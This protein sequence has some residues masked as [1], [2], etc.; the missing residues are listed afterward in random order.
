M[1]SSDS[2]FSIGSVSLMTNSNLKCMCKPLPDS[3]SSSLASSAAA[4]APAPVPAA[5]PA[6]VAAAAPPPEPTFSS[7]SL[8]SLPSS[9]WSFLSALLYPCPADFTGSIPLKTALSRSARRL[10]HRQ[11][12]SGSEVYRPKSMLV[13]DHRMLALVGGLAVISTPSSARM[14]AA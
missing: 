4:S 12:L 5:P 10:P 9:A 1:S 11:P 2:S 13:S 14:R 7:R 6:V 3:F 8:M